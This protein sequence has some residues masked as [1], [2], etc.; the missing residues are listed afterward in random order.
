MSPVPIRAFAKPLLI[1]VMAVLVFVYV[2][3]YAYLSRRGMRE[4]KKYDMGGFLY[5]PLDDALQSHD[6]SRHRFL[7]FLYGP[8]SSI[9]HEILGTDGPALCMMFDLS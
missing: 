3:S 4:A 6:L 5:V 1:V 9:D 2:G 7:M 8:L